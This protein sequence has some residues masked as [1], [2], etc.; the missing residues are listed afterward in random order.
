MP[1]FVR[2]GAAWFV[3]ASALLLLLAGCDYDAPPEVRLE[4]PPD[5]VWRSGEALRLSFSEPVEPASLLLR[6]WPEV[7]DVEGELPSDAA[8][9]LADCRATGPDCG[10]A[11][12]TVAADRRSAELWLDPDG[13]GKA[14]APL[15]LEV[16]PGL[17]D[18]AGRRT[19]TA[20]W[21]PLQFLPAAPDDPPETEVP[22]EDGIY[23][24]V[25]TLDEPAPAVMTYVTQV[26]A[27]RDGRVA[28]AGAEGDEIEGALKSTT[29]PRELFV[30]TTTEGYTVHATGRL[31]LV[32]G[33]RF[34]STEPFPIEIVTN[35]IVVSLDAV[36]IHATVVREAAVDGSVHDHLSGTFA[37][38][39][40]TLT[41][42]E[43]SFD[44]EGG[45]TGLVGV[46]VPAGTCEAGAPEVCGDPCGAVVLGRC[47]PPEGFPGEGFCAAWEEERDGAAAEGP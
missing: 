6:V 4:L 18:A 17:A 2:P 10:E 27:L 33:D 35:G 14:G 36:R 45:T 9:L 24:L 40:A 12:L 37:F 16:L 21:F 38:E 42:G 19:R 41:I 3:G 28:L 47:A 5:G 11:R 32:E 8:P 23:L 26:V 44:Y 15:L 46:W 22:F 20:R 1:R 43:R 31:Q 30:D 25:G 7:R 34:L 13:L 29:D 39:G